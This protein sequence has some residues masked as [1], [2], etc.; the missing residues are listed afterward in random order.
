MAEK[1]KN[2]I[3]Y[4]VGDFTELLGKRWRCL[5]DNQASPPGQA[6]ENWTHDP[7]VEVNPFVQV[8][9]K[10]PMLYL[11]LASSGDIDTWKVNQNPKDSEEN[12]I[13]LKSNPNPSAAVTDDG[14]KYLVEMQLERAYQDGYR[15]MC[16]RTINGARTGNVIRG[17][18]VPSASWSIADPNLG[19]WNDNTNIR[20]NPPSGIEYPFTST[21]RLVSDDPTAVIGD[22][23]ESL[24]VFL[25]S[26]IDSKSDDPVDVYIYDGYQLAFHDPEQTQPAR[27]NLAMTWQNDF[28]WV[29][30]TNNNQLHF[31]H[32]DFS[33]DSHV[34]FREGEILPWRDEI[35]ISGFVVD[36]ASRAAKSTQAP[37]YFDFYRDRGLFIMGEAVPMI[38]LGGGQGFIFDDEVIEAAPYQG[39]YINGGL[40]DFW[41]NRGWEDK[42]PSENSE[43]HISLTWGFNGNPNAWS[44]RHLSGDANV[45]DIESMKAEIDGMIDAGYVVGPAFGYYVDASPATEAPA[46]EEI[47]RYIESRSEVEI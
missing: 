26:W 33:I 35:G 15:R 22:R 38:N 31:P 41:G 18:G 32:P 21:G 20:D 47:I 24:R 7:I 8:V 39:L 16:L 2:T 44:G 6:H 29:N 5:R 14:I 12:P 34:E 10:R 27:G 36:G 4:R 3:I 9:D 11:N 25:K 46:R 28:A 13:Y 23:Q 1:W 40:G 17:N 37:G 19:T 42:T 43:I 30:N 45:Y